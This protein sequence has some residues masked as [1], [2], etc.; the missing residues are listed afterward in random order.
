[1]IQRKQTIWLLLASLV[2]LGLFFVSLYKAASVSELTDAAGY[3]HTT[4]RL[5]LMLNAGIITLVP[6]L[7]I[8]LFKDRKRQRTLAIFCIIACL[9]FISLMWMVANNVN[10]QLAVSTQGSWQPGALLPFVAIVF[11]ILAISGI[12]KDEKLVKSMDRLR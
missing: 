10:H 7:A 6:F 1:M 12:N 9:S 2:N 3:I 4:N 5:T 8:F 11:L